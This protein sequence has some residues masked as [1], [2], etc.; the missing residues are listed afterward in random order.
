LSTDPDLAEIFL[1]GR[2]DPHSLSP[3]E[4]ERFRAFCMDLMNVAV[5]QD[6]LQDAHKLVPLHYDMVE[7]VGSM[8]QNYP[9]FKLVADS[10]EGITPRNLVSRF[11]KM[12]S[13]FQFVTSIDHDDTNA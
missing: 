6:G 9:G 8:Y 7:A 11:R 13:S 3:I 4:F 12:E 5:Y 2:D 1:K 10:V